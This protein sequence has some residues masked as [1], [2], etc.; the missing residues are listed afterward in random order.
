MIQYKV[1]VPV[2]MLGAQD[3]FG[4]FIENDVELVGRHL[5]Y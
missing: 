1:W 3:F 5:L 4:Y 2:G